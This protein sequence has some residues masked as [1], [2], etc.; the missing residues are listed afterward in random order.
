VT[1]REHL[2]QAERRGEPVWI[3]D[4]TLVETYWIFQHLYNLKE[5]DAPEIL[6][7][8]TADARFLFQSGSGARLALERTKI[9]GDLPGHLIALEARQAGAEVTSCS[10]IFGLS[11][12]PRP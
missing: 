9:K 3:A 7:D 12:T 2:A 4:V 6:V 11:L 5:A 8:L 1:V 10:A